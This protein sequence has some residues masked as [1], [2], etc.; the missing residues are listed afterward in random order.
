MIPAAEPSTRPGTPL[1][2]SSAEAVTKSEIVVP[3]SGSTRITAPRSTSTSPNGFTSSDSV[4]GGFRRD[5]VRGAPERERELGE[6]GRLERERADAEPPARAVHRLGDDEHGDA[7]RE[8]GDE[9]RRRERAQLPEVE[10]RGEDQQPEPEQRVRA[11]ALQEL[12]RVVAAERGRRG[13]RAV[14]HHQPEGGETERDEDEDLWLEAPLLHPRRV[15]TSRLN[16]CPRCSKSRNWS[17][18]AAAGERSTT[19]P[20]SARRAATDTACCERLRGL[21]RH[22]DAARAPRR[23]RTPSP[24][25]ARPPSRVLLPPPRAARSSPPCRARRR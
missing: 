6:L 1:T 22:A 20:G 3:R 8:G 25:R 16:S 18:L 9:E 13:R 14:D 19:S 17:K 10:P 4:C 5:E 24:R 21:V 15:R 2:S 23:A 7:E 12:A 11:L